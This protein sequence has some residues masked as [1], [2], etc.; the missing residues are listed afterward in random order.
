VKAVGYWQI[1]E[2]WDSVVLTTC[3]RVFQLDGIGLDWMLGHVTAETARLS[4][5][6][7]GLCVFI[8]ALSVRAR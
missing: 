5:V 8:V 2:G 6:S 4:G 1:R 3:A 7:R